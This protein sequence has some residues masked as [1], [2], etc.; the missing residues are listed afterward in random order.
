MKKVMYFG[1]VFVLLAG[2]MA[3]FAN[4]GRQIPAKTAD[5]RKI[6]Y[7]V[8]PMHPVYKSDKPG[9]APD[10]GM[11]LVPVYE[12]AVSESTASAAPANVTNEISERQRQLIGVQVNPAQVSTTEY[13]LRL[14]GRV[15]PD[16]TRVYKLNAGIDG[17]IQ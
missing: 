4:R 10:C 3:A 5:S 16:D 1:V 15:M 8:D 7:Y 11:E 9:T 13:R 14:L 6:L 2:I 12:D 17:Y